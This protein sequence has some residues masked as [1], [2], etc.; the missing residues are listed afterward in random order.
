MMRRFRVV[1]SS[2][3][4]YNSQIFNCETRIRNEVELPFTDEKY[5]CV[6]FNGLQIKL[7]KDDK[8]IIANIW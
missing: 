5:R 3:S 6:M 2:V 4:N 1:E 8:I 7:V